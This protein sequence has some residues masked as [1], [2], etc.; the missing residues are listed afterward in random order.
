MKLLLV[1]IDPPYAMRCGFHIGVHIKR[2]GGALHVADDCPV[3][4]VASALKTTGVPAASAA[5]ARHRGGDTA[6]VKARRRLPDDVIVGR[7]ISPLWW[8]S[9]TVTIIATVREYGP[10]SIF[11]AISGTHA[12][13]KTA[14]V[15]RH[16]SAFERFWRSVDRASELHTG[17]VAKYAIALGGARPGG[18]A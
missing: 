8:R 15:L 13:G 6:S 5:S 9:G 17:R 12:C 2:M 1:P 3:G 11:L 18:A 16:Q 4:V 14:V 7:G 10:S